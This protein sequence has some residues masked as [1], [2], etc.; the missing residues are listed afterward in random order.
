MSVAKA[1]LPSSFYHEA[2][3]RENTTA[4]K[5]AALLG[6]PLR[7]WADEE[8]PAAREEAAH[9]LLAHVLGYKIAAVSGVGGTCVAS[10]M[11]AKSAPP[12]FKTDMQAISLA[13]VALEDAVTS[14][15]SCLCWA[16]LE[17][18]MS[19]A[20]FAMLWQNTDL[21]GSQQALKSVEQAMVLA[22]GFLA[23]HRREL[24]R[25]ADALGRNGL[26]SGDDVR[27]LVDNQGS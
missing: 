11:R 10:P 14:Y 27:A 19:P 3:M 23:L 5:R 15:R 18:R 7:R 13:G 17:R 25:L 22:R 8:L 16:E 6:R 12:S 2:T 24:D 26:L 20:D 4:Q 21:P 9:A 1:S